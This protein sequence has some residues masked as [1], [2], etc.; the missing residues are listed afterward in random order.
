VLFA[1]RVAVA[2]VLVALD[3]LPAQQQQALVQE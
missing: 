3:L 1:V 2:V